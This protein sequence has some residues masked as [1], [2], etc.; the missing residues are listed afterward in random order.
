ME[1]A[2]EADKD[3]AAS[4][5]LLPGDARWTPLFDAFSGAY[6][7][8][9]LD[10]I[11]VK[12]YAAYEPTERNWRVREGYGALIAAFARPLD[13]R[14]NTP[15][16]KIEHGGARVVRVMTPG[17]A[18]EAKAVVVAV[19]SG[20]LAGEGIAFDPPLPDHLQAAVDLPLGHV[21]KA[22]LKLETPGL[23]PPDTRAY[24]RVDTADAGSYTLRPMGMP[25]VEAYFGGDIAAELGREPGA[26]CRF[27]MEELAALFGAEVRAAF[28]PIAESGWRADPFVRGAY[29]HAK[30]GRTGARAVMATSAGERLFFAGEACSPHA[31]STAHGAYETGLAAAQSVL[32]GLRPAAPDPAPN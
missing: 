16:L 29:S 10:E 6:N 5:L 21:E 28:S 15:A 13:V 9:P 24:G 12:D 19:S 26:L 18:I 7:G 30:A 3:Q 14:L 11:S 2:A 31:F 22:F 1:K 20:V 27:A 8:A 4:A 25:V 32:R 23:F 17:G